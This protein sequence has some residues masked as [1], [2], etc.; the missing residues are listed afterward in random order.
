MNKHT[1]RLL[2]VSLVT[3]TGLAHAETNMTHLQ[4]RPAGVNLAMEKTTWHTQVNKKIVKEDDKF[5]AS[6]QAVGFY[7]ESTNGGGLGKYF[8]FANRSNLTV[9]PASTTVAG[10]IDRK[11]LIHHPLAVGTAPVGAPSLAGTLNLKFEHRQAGLRLDYYQDLDG[12]LKGLFFKVNAPIV[13]AQ[14]RSRLGL[15]ST[16]GE[17]VNSTTNPLKHVNNYFDGTLGHTLQQELQKA[18]I[19][20]NRSKTALADIDF[21]LGWNIWETED[22]HAGINL[23]VTF[24]TSPDAKGEYLFEPLGGGNGGHWG[25][26]AGGDAKFKVW[27]DEDQCLEL[28]FALNYRYLFKGS[29]TRTLGL[30]KDAAH[31]NWGHNFL[32]GQTGQSTLIPLANI[33]TGKVDVT[34]GSQVDFQAG[35]SY[36]NGGFTFDLGYNLYARVSENVKK[37]FTLTADTYGLAGNNYDAAA[38]A[39]LFALA[40]IPAAT[41]AVTIGQ[42]RVS[43]TGAWMLDTELTT[44]PC[45]TPSYVTHKIYGGLGYC[46]NEWE[47]PFMLGLGAH[48]EFASSQKTLE[49]W[50]IFGKLGISF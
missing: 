16:T 13:W 8:G 34:P 44:R 39:N 12:L 18:K 6:L 45:T 22:H 32:V 15:S 2:A 14:T 50:G 35:L 21:I 30:Y 41:T 11:H 49:Q 48:Y 28:D 3:L 4:P 23:G 9:G 27:K 31:K 29:E 43:G 24:P 46:F 1:K 26:G 10:R 33:S 47:T 36:R 7:E 37:K 5:G 42:T 19:T 40:D 20:G 25:L 38:G 17:T